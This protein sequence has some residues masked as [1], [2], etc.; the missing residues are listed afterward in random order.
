[1]LI[2]QLDAVLYAFGSAKL[3]IP[4]C[5][6]I[7]PTIAFGKLNICLLNDGALLFDNGFKSVFRACVYQILSSFKLH[8]Q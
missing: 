6:Q 1:M 7:L 2:L 5:D 3:K 4:N 8:K